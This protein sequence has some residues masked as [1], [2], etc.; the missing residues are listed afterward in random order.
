M[1]P[2]PGRVRSGPIADAVARTIAAPVLGRL[3]KSGGC[4]TSAAKID[5]AA[6]IKPRFAHRDMPIIA[7]APPLTDASTQFVKLCQ[8]KSIRDGIA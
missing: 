7:L 3:A 1:C 6:D 5:E 4:R 2:D 8:V